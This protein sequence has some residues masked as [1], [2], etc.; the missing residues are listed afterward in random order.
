MNTRTSIFSTQRALMHQP[1]DRKESADTI[2]YVAGPK[3]RCASGYIV[4]V[5]GK[6]I[7][8]FLR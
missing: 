7:E 4:P 3:S 8:A 5:N 1:G 6:S 2:L